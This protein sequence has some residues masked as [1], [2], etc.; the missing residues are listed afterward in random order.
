M[1]EVAFTRIESERLR[2]RR[3]KDSD[4][5]PFMAYRNDP[6]VA[7]Y[8]SWDS[9]DEREARAF[10]REVKSA[11]PGVPG[12]WFQFAMESKGM[13]D[14]VGDCGLRVDEH[15]PYRA[16]IGFTL[17]PEYQGRGFASEAVSRLLDYAFEAL[18]LHRVVAI[19]DCRNAPSVA[20]L[21]RVGMR[22]EGHFLENVW[23]K[24]GWA[25]EYLYAVLKD[26]WLQKRAI[27]C[28]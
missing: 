15:E 13:G 14:L 20:L 3:F 17:A 9:C 28:R 23:F 4:L 8:Q 24:G 1:S 19:S 10:I 6:K 11:Q 7:R 16:E 26:E 25:D 27:T 22:R 12:D 18:G 5:S 21:E 2:I